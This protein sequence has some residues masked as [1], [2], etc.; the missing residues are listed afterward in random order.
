MTSRFEQDLTLW[1]CR[2]VQDLMPDKEELLGDTRS[3]TVQEHKWYRGVIGMMCYYSV[4]TRWDIPF[5]VNMAAQFLESPTQGAL[6]AAGRIMAYLV[7]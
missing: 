3:V 2:T 1:G 5:D 7:V 6:A 4:Q